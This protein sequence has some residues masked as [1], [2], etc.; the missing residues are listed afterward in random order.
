MPRDP[1][2]PTLPA[3][4]WYV[5]PWGA[6]LTQPQGIRFSLRAMPQERDWPAVLQLGDWPRFV[7][8]WATARVELKHQPGAGVDSLHIEPA[9][10][11]LAYLKAHHLDIDRASQLW[12]A[13]FGDLI[14]KMD[15]APAREA[16]EG[17]PR[18]QGELSSVHCSASLASLSAERMASVYHDTYV[19]GLAHGMAAGTVGPA[20][21][22]AYS[23]TAL[24]GAASLYTPHTVPSRDLY[25]QRETILNNWKAA[26]HPV[27]GEAEVD[28]WCWDA[29]NVIAGEAGTN[30]PLGEEG[31]ARVPHSSTHLDFLFTK[32][33]DRSVKTHAACFGEEYDMDEFAV[34]FARRK[35]VY[36]NAGK[37]EKT[38][39]TTVDKNI[40]HQFCT[41][42]AALTLHPW[43]AKVLGLTLCF[44]EPIGAPLHQCT[45]IALTMV[46]TLGIPADDQKWTQLDNGFPSPLKAS[47]NKVYYKEGLLNL[48]GTGQAFMLTQLDVDRTPDRY[49]QA[50]S[51]YRTEQ[52]SGG[53]PAGAGLTTQPQETI[54]FSV[55]EIGDERKR[56]ALAPDSG[57][58]SLLYL[59]HLLSGYR[60]DVSVNSGAWAPLT[61][62]R[63]RRV[64]LHD[65]DVSHW[66]RHIARCEAIITEK[67]RTTGATSHLE[68]ELFRWGTAGLG[69]GPGGS[70]TEKLA[71]D[72]LDG[73]G[74][75]NE[76]K[77][78]YETV[79]LPAQRYGQHYRFGARLAMID[80]NSRELALATWHYDAPSGDTVAIG[81]GEAAGAGQTCLRFE[82]VAPPTVLLTRAP[83][84]RHFPKESARHLV[85]ATSSHRSHCRASTERVLA[86]P[87][88]ASLDLCLRHGEFD[89]YRGHHSWPASAFGDVELNENGDFPSAIS[90]TLDADNQRRQSEEQYYKAAIANERPPIPYYPDPWATTA[91]LA[92][93]R[94]GDHRLLYCDRYDYYQAGKRSWPQCRA[95][96][97]RLEADEMGGDRDIGLAASI[98]HSGLTVKLRPG[99]EVILRV[100]HHLTQDMMEQF[101]VVGQMADLEYKLAAIPELHLAATPGLMA[102]SAPNL[103]TF[104]RR[105]AA[106]MLAAKTPHQ[107]PDGPKVDSPSYWML[108]PY[109]E[110]SLVHA[111]DQP[112]QPIEQCKAAPL[113]IDRPAGETHARFGGRLLLDR[114]STQDLRGTGRWTDLPQRAAKAEDGRYALVPVFKDVSLFAVP[115]IALVA[116]DDSGAPALTPMDACLADFQRY[117]RLDAS[118]PV[119]AEDQA[120]RINATTEVDL[121]DTR[122]RVIEVVTSGA[123]RLADEFG[124]QDGMAFRRQAVICRVVVQGTQRPPAPNIE[125]VA[126]VFAW[127]GAIP[128]T[129]Q[130]QH[131]RQA[132]WFRIWLGS[133]WYE[134]GNGELLALVCW[135]GATL[136]VP[137]SLL[138]S[139]L[140]TATG[141][142]A[143]PPLALEPAITRWGLDPVI[144]QGI[145]FGNM[146]LDAMKNRL[147]KCTD[148]NGTGGR[149]EVLCVDLPHLEDL[150]AYDPTIDLALLEEYRG[151]DFGPARELSRKG[152]HVQLALY[153]PMLDETS[154]RMFVD[155]QIDPALAYQP[156]VRLALARFQAHARHGELEELRLSPIVATEFIQLMPK[157]TATLTSIRDEKKGVYQVS[158]TIAG[159]TIPE[160]QTLTTRFFA[161]IELRQLNFAKDDEINGGWVPVTT[162]SE[163]QKLEFDAIRGV[164]DCCI[165]L[166]SRVS[167]EYS[168]RIEEYEQM[169]GEQDGRL[170]YFDRLPLRYF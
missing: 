159:T 152:S 35:M 123:S 145:E 28:K 44:D 14:E 29:L 169:A 141:D 39:L 24:R 157:R 155:I 31:G 41:R 23:R 170:V 144:G 16:T 27:A 133:T 4:D 67:T 107:L 125:Y 84:H 115:N 103:D 94:K 80:G 101:A 30:R 163:A 86:P 140:G 161:S 147:R 54:G 96:T 111:V 162:D 102:D 164:W 90:T 151:L 53:K 22:G 120:P 62:R 95:L 119:R 127:D 40:I 52:L 73:A 142:P 129:D 117:Q 8:Q 18:D 108:N 42:A 60:P 87:R 143:Y 46:G 79:D 88:G 100:W 37:L 68:G 148:L 34:E 99:I 45:Q 63:L 74:C 3:V 69:A 75:L 166:H 83:E 89:R 13:I 76:L 156:F 38:S 71:L 81:G 72:A 116:A 146:P 168:V 17:Y 97:V 19:H 167:Y 118:L 105:L 25:W 20:A 10:R 78:E 106:H 21:P 6:S 82:P 9:S 158:V 114:P 112:V 49:V 47:D 11:Y 135:P 122:A 92:I 154:G 137:P 136:P 93:Y 26:S 2:R 32:L 59:E 43:L 33:R 128:A 50:A 64:T 165:K 98:D 56:A 55:I 51:T 131:I 104:R 70:T 110:L 48:S 109:V 113:S 149:D 121:G 66:F 91:V 12:Q 85:V 77:I 134:S 15:E 160:G 138:N 57:S 58:P 61:A 132:G 126:P 124:G 5:V 65:E 139:L 36:A 150:E 153:R 130:T 1:A 7:A